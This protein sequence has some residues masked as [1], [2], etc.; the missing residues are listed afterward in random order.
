MVDLPIPI[1]MHAKMAREIARFPK[2]RPWLAIDPA[3]EE[4]C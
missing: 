2:A 4:I 3:W 1:S